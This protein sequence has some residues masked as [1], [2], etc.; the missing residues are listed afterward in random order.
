MLKKC[1][2]L[3]AA[4]GFALAQLASAQNA[5]SAELAADGA[6]LDV[7]PAWEIPP[8]SRRKPNP[9]Y[10]SGS[11]PLMSAFVSVN[12][13]PEGD[14]PSEIAFSADGANIV[15]AHRDSH[16][17]VV[18]D[19]A[20]RAVL[21]VIDVTGSPNSLALS[22]DNVHAVTA[23]LFE[24][25]ASILDLVAGVEVAVVAVGDQ[26][27]IVRITPDGTTAIVGN[28]LDGSLSV[29]DIQTASEVRVIQNAGFT[30]I[31][32]FGAWGV[33]YRFTDFALTPDNTTIIFPDNFGQLINFFDIATGS[34]TGIVP[35][36]S[37]YGIDLSPDGTSC[38][39]AHSHPESRVTVVDVAT[40]SITKT[41][42]VGG[43]AASVP[44]I[45]IDPSGTKCVV[46]VLNG[47]RVVNLVTDLVGG[48]LSTGSVR[49]LG[50]TADGLFCVVGNYQASLVSYTSESIVA[51]LMS[52]TTPDGLAVSPADAR[53][54]T[55]HA[56]RKEH[57]EVLDVSGPGGSLEGGVPTGPEPEGDKARGVA[58]SADG[59]TAVVIN[60]HSQN[61]TVI[62]L[63]TASI[64]DV[65][66]TGE[67]PGGVAL[68]PDG[69]TAVVANLD[70]SFATVIDLVTGTPTNV[71]ISR[72]G[73]AV[74]IS[75]DG[76]YAYIP[77]VADG[78]GVWRIDLNTMSVDG[79]KIFTG[80]MGGVGYVFDTASGIA[81]SHDG[82]TLVTCGS[83]DND[84]SIIDTATWTELARVSVGAFPTRAA[85]AP[86]DAT[87][88]VSNKNNDTV[89]LVSNAAGASAVTDTIS[90]G[91]QP[92]E[93]TTNPSGTTLYVANFNA[94]TISVIDL[95]GNTVTNT[96]V[97]P[98]P[99]GVGQPVGLHAT[100]DGTRLYVAA[101]GADY[102]EIDTATLTITETLNTGLAP[103][104]L[105]YSEANQAGYMPSPLGG[106]GI[107]IV[108]R[109]SKAVCAVRNGGGMNPSGFACVS[110]PIIGMNWETTV[111]VATPAA[112]ASFVLMALGGPTMGAVLSGFVTGELLALP[113][114]HGIDAGV[115]SHSIAIPANASFVG[116]SFSTQGAT[117]Q[118]GFVQLNNAIDI[119][120]GTF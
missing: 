114:F 79:G 12:V 106:D 108:S 42:A 44:P 57:M 112:S 14:T 71:D 29:V 118:S 78:D 53:A 93:L 104:M 11:A 46:T 94:R 113:P 4:C 91:D 40:Q 9:A 64:S 92:F 62:D 38:V 31:T 16:N 36:P 26:P 41:I 58:V 75:P 70:S 101:N 60:N 66:P 74:V 24:D 98:Q 109:G 82:A 30:Q 120:I 39:I 86:N 99:G 61:A 27:G 107:S 102:H 96:I 84:V 103:T 25:T 5:G 33:T 111:D 22:S 110:D 105:C 54:A 13:P 18:F 77:V 10:L 43:P 37:P 68:T 49:S 88:Y 6:D 97:L 100:L 7:R 21:Q 51:S 116:Q 23:N 83:F 95:S 115:G 72:R 63:L 52:S 69:G 119:T 32:S 50:T 90:V 67:R 28:T 17:L 85:F 76:Q 56:L 73:S 117:L 89:S 65:V 59:T 55:I 48:V 34:A 1:F 3:V 15:I 20:T 87:I 8:P 81:L 35:D 2:V 19:A 45:V 47:V 80:N